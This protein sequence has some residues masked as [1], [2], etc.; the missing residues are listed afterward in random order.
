MVLPTRIPK[1]HRD[2]K[3]VKVQVLLIKYLVLLGLV[4]LMLLGGENNVLVSLTL[5]LRLFNFGIEGDVMTLIKVG[6]MEITR[7]TNGVMVV[8]IEIRRI[9]VG[10]HTT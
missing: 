3:V 7:K 5:D 9:D 10:C 8:P 2:A 6:V 4:V 1:T